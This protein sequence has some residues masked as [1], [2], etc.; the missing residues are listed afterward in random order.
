MLQ[1]AQ[2]PKGPSVHPAQPVLAQIQA[3][4]RA[5]AH[6]SSRR[7][8][9]HTVVIQQQRAYASAQAGRYRGQRTP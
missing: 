2:T 9:A 3:Q 1:R 4:Q 7:Q 8:R 6:E 5:S